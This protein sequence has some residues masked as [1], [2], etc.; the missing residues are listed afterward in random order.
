SGNDNLLSAALHCIPADTVGAYAMAEE[1]EV[2]GEEVTYAAAVYLA[3]EVE[4]ATA[5]GARYDAAGRFLG[6]TTVTLAPGAV[7]QVSVA[8]ENGETVRIFAV[9]GASGAPLCEAVSF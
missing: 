3:P 2:S 9:D 8:A 4:T 7:T 1:P 5:F 6:F